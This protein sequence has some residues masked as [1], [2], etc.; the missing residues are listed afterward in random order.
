MGRIWICGVTG[1]SGTSEKNQWLLPSHM[2]QPETNPPP[3]PTAP[4]AT[5]PVQPDKNQARYVHDALLRR[6]LAYVGGSLA[7]FLPLLEF[8]LLS[9]Q[10]GRLLLP[11]VLSGLLLFAGSVLTVSLTLA[12][13]VSFREVVFIERIGGFNPEKVIEAY[14]PK[15]RLILAWIGRFGDDPN[16]DYLDAGLVLGWMLVVALVIGLCLSVVWL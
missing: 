10:S 2:A 9:R 4:V 14:R 1:R 16:S 13:I 12:A 6:T 7:A 5:P 15:S 3:G 8:V 11:P